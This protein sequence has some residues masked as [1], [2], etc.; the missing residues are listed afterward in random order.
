MIKLDL[1][2]YIKVYGKVR[3][4]LKEEDKESIFVKK[5][6]IVNT[7]L[8][9]IA[10]ILSGESGNIKWCQLGTSDVP[11]QATQETLVEPDETTKTNITE[12][13]F[14]NNV[15]SFNTFYSSSQAIGVWKEAGLL[16]DESKLFSR[17]T[18]P[19]L[20]KTSSATLSIMWDIII[21]R[22]E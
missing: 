1:E 16:D 6:M 9:T 7:G 8:F 14:F 15:V 18:F 13:S 22:R 11:E 3:I 12:K 4:I 17:I 5:N 19:P 20:Q 21:E 10:K 2:R